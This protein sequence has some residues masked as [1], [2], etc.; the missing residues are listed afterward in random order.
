[1]PLLGL[2][3]VQLAMPAGREDEARAFYSGVLG[4]IELPK[5]PALAGRGGAWFGNETVQLH[6]GVEADFRPARKAHPAVRVDD[7]RAVA[8]ACHAAGFAP[9]FDETLPGV[10]R[11]YV[12]DPFG[13]RLEFLQAPID[14]TT[15]DGRREA[16]HAL[17]APR[18]GVGCL[19]VR[20]GQL[21]LVQSRRTLRWSTPGGHL[22]FGESPA[23]CAARETAEEAGLPVTNI[24][25]VAITNDVLPDTGS[26]Y[27]TIWMRADAD[28]TPVV[29]DRE[30]IAAAGWFSAE[31]SAATIAS[32]LRQPHCR[33]VPSSE[34]G[35]PAVCYRAAGTGALDGWPRHVRNGVCADAR[36]G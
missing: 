36:R 6:L 27:V 25:F 3:H 18:V 13:N 34:P 8:D 24:E 15:P 4:L 29:G 31:R 19:V 9:H 22:D 16:P 1:M 35:E 30:E 28:G 11:F 10:I 12:D 26:H 5:P 33:A 2:D 32:V 14:V 17:Q 7:L 21:L 23:E 20:S